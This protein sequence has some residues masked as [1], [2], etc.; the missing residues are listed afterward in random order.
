MP[1]LSMLIKPASGSCNLRCRY[2]FYHDVS[3]NRLKKSFGMMDTE[4]LEILVKKALAFADQSCTFSFQ[5]G[6]PMLAGMDFFRQLVAFQKQYNNKNVKICNSIQT[7]GTLTDNKWAWFFKK[8]HFL[9]GLSL[10]GTKDVHDAMRIDARG[11]GSFDKVMDA[12]ERF[13]L[14]GVDYNIL[15]VVNKH[16]AE[17]IVDIYRFFREKNF[18][19][20]QPIPCLDPLGEKPGGNAFSLVPEAYTFFLK[21]LFGLWYRDIMSGHPIVIRNFDNYIGMLMG[22]R[23]EMCSMLGECICQYVVEADGSVY[24]CDFYVLDEWVLGNIK[25][26]DM[27]DIGACETANRFVHVSRHID[28]AC[29]ACE[30]N[31]LCRGGCRRNRE[32]F[33]DG[34]PGLNYFCDSYKAFFQYAMPGLQDIKQMLLQRR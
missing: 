5:G 28:P 23:P 22:Y 12:S 1:P 6:E 20:I 34:K 18:A 4:T 25:E 19:F 2:C 31:F 16:V 17:N 7:N 24:P 9:V 3:E 32:P 13:D 15:C 11:N 27:R 26:G 10:D 8:N 21:R 30:W 33:T 14:Y 29:R